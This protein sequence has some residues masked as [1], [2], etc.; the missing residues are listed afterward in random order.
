[1]NTR[2]TVQA[3]NPELTR[4]GQGIAALYI[5]SHEKGKLCAQSRLQNWTPNKRK[6]EQERLN[7]CFNHGSAAI[8][9]QRLKHL[10]G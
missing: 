10:S 5:V 6:K 9:P 3:D 7:P 4:H 8:K 2:V 1:V